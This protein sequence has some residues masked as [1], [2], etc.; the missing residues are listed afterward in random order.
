M[1]VDL[2]LKCNFFKLRIQVQSTTAAACLICDFRL[3]A[4]LATG[5]VGGGIL[6]EQY[7]DMP[8]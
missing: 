5:I 7:P 2:N 3:I 8:V 4:E 1:L 6:P